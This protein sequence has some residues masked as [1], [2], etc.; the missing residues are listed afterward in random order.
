MWVSDYD[1][2]SHLAL[3]RC[4]AQK[5]LLNSNCSLKGLISPFN[6]L[7][8]VVKHFYSIPKNSFLVMFNGWEDRSMTW[9][10][11]EVDFSPMKPIHVFEIVFPHPGLYSLS[12]ILFLVPMTFFYNPTVVF[13]CYLHPIF[14]LKY[15]KVEEARTGLTN[16]V[17][18]GTLQTDQEGMTIFLCTPWWAL[19]GKVW[20][21]GL[22]SSERNTSLCWV[23][24]YCGGQ[25]RWILW[26][27]P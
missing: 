16:L 6:N 22:C 10:L 5:S 9:V 8:L 13:F 17:R 24:R 25:A 7:F 27:C 26:R 19:E 23:C 11:R 12:P 2:V 3:R 15:L 4:N 18:R 20:P 1:Y 21:E 14:G